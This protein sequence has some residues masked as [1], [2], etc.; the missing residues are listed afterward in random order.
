MNMT[1]NDVHPGPLY[2]QRSENVKGF[3]FLLRELLL[4]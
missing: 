2:W 3:G 1:I 4:H